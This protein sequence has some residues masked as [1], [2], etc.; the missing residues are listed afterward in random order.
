[1]L[2]VYSRTGSQCS[3]VFLLSALKARKDKVMKQDS[4]A[5]D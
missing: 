5:S 3:D 1:M 4:L 2:A